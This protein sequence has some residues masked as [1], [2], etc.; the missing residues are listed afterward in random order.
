MILSPAVGVVVG[1]LCV[2]E[3]DLEQWSA[4][5]ISIG[6]GRTGSLPGWEQSRRDQHRHMARQRQPSAHSN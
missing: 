1:I 5:T 6:S 4:A 3:V 2:F